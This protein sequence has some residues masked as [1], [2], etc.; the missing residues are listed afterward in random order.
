[1]EQP[2]LFAILEAERRSDEDALILKAGA[3]VKERQAEAQAKADTEVKR[4]YLTYAVP[5]LKR[6]HRLGKPKI[7]SV[8]EALLLVALE[9]NGYDVEGECPNGTSWHGDATC[10]YG[11]RGS[12]IKT[13]SQNREDLLVSLWVAASGQHGG[14]F[15]NESVTLTEQHLKGSVRRADIRAL[16]SEPSEVDTDPLMG[17][18]N[19]L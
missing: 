6:E 3:L 16:R 1:M 4:L 10:R 14:E 19:P 12:I 8:R 5:R 13:L 15:G 2:S 9:I 11:T 7:L 18:F 17:E